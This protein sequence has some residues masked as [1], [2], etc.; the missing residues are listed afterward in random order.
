[1]AFVVYTQIKEL[2]VQEKEI[3]EFGNW[4]RGVDSSVWDEELENYDSDESGELPLNGDGN[5][6]EYPWDDF[7]YVIVPDSD[8]DID[9]ALTVGE[10]LGITYR[11]DIFDLDRVFF[12]IK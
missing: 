8:S 12:V 3:Y 2:K 1:M 6:M 7:S 11:F 10:S 9:S 4:L 5:V